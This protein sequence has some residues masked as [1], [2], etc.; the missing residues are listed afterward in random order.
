MN[1]L[2]PELAKRTYGSD[3][4]TIAKFPCTKKRRITDHKLLMGGGV[5]LM[6]DISPGM[7]ASRQFDALYSSSTPPVAVK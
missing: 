4:I 1:G 2:E 5:F 3:V 6:A 7:S